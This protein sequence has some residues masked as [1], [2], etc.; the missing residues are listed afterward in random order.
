MG[1][2]FHPEDEAPYNSLYYA[3]SKWLIMFLRTFKRG[4]PPTQGLLLHPQHQK[5]QLEACDPIFKAILVE[6]TLL[7]HSRVQNQQ[8]PLLHQW[9]Q[10]PRVV[11]FSASSVE[12]M[13]MSLRSVQIIM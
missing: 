8:H 7:L 13:V 6:R 5:V 9:V 3:E 4:R 1:K 2:D 12:V 11:V 10:Q